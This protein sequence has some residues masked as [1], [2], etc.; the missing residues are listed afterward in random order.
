MAVVIATG[1]KR[2]RY[3]APDQSPRRIA[4]RIPPAIQLT[5]FI[6]GLRILK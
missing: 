2:G 6:A 4:A 3:L 5:R 1:V